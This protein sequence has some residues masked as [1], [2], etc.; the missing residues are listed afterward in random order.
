MESKNPIKCFDEW[1]NLRKKPTFR[2]KLY[3]V[4]FV[5]TQFVRVL[6]IICIQTTA[7]RQLFLWFNGWLRL[8]TSNSWR[9]SILHLHALSLHSV[10]FIEYQQQSK[11]MKTRAISS[12]RNNAQQQQQ[13]QQAIDQ[14]HVTRVATQLSSVS[15]ISRKMGIFFGSRQ[16]LSN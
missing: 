7:L 1:N 16:S 8:W 2:D 14:S 3:N 15:Q 12:S 6:S 11:L 10:I 9:W 5:E 4:S 13:Q